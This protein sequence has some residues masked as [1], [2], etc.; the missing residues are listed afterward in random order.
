[1]LLLN[2]AHPLTSEQIEQI[3]HATLI[4]A[5]LAVTDVPTQF[6]PSQSYVEQAR[7]LIDGISL[8]STEWQTASLLINL[9]GHSSIA[10]CVLAELHGRTGHFPSIIRLKFVET[11]AAPSYE[12]AEVIN[13]QTARELGR[14]RRER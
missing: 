4:P 14:L 13:L 11:L 8:S 6:D 5:P 2:F 10:A 3:E 12:L 9:P 7:T 1:M